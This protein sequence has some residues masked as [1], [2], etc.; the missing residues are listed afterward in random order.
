MLHILLMILKITG[1]IL[2]SILA[3]ILF[4]LLIILFVPIRYTADGKKNETD[5]YGRAR[6]SWLFGLIAFII[7]YQEKNLKLQLKIFGI[8]FPKIVK[9]LKSKKLQKRDK[10]EKIEDTK[11]N[12][13][14]MKTAEAGSKDVFPKIEEPA[15]PEDNIPSKIRGII[16]KIKLTIVSI[17]DKI[18][19]WKDFLADKR[20]R[21]ALSVAKTQLFKIVKHILPKK[22]K[23][24]V[25]YGFE[26]PCMTGQVLAGVS[27]VYPFYYKH[28]SIYPDFSAQVFL[29]D[30]SVR[31]RIYVVYLLK[32]AL[33][34]FFH[35]NVQFIINTFRNK[36]DSKNGKQ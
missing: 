7:L 4:L 17:C 30:M 11:E 33:A 35:K 10:I 3:L 13:E 16:E 25:T 28:I 20:V 15:L 6:I 14:S 26:D 21:S 32:C 31:G 34:V 23:G 8:D 27:M 24:Q 5:L 1:I 22:I 12:N 2:L 19:Y 9:K 29:G 18:K 36:E